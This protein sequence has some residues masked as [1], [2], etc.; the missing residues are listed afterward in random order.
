MKPA[1]E[2]SAMFD[3]VGFESAGSLVSVSPIDGQPIGRVTVGDPDHACA[4]AAEAFR[5]WRTVP[6]P[7]RG[8]LVRLLGAKPSRSSPG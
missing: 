3:L 8:E 5:E 1:D 7:R 4:R 6:A 2:V